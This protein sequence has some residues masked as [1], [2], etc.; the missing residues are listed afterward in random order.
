M[1]GGQSQKQKARKYAPIW[2]NRYI[3]GYWPNRNPLRDAALPV[4]QE[5]FYGALNDALIAGQDCE[6]NLRSELVRRAGTSV[7]NSNTFG[8]QQRFFSFPV[9]GV[10]GTPYRRILASSATQID[11]ITNGGDT[12]LYLKPAGAAKTVFQNIGDTTFFAD[13]VLPQQLLSFANSWTANTTFPYGTEIVDTNGNIQKSLGSAV[14]ITDVNV[15][16]VSGVS[17]LTITFSGT[18]EIAIGD[19]ASFLGLT[20]ATFLNNTSVVVTATT[21]STFSAPI[22]ASA[23]AT[24]A[25]T[26]V[27]YT[28]ALPL[29]SA[30]LQTIGISSDVLTIFFSGVGPSTLVSG[31][32]VTF[33]GITNPTFLFLNGTTMTISTVQYLHGTRYSGS[34]TA[35]NITPTATGSGYIT[36]PGP[37]AETGATQPTWSST[38][39]GVTFDGTTAWVFSGPAVRN[40][41]IVAP[42]TAPIVANTPASTG[43]GT[44]V[45]STYYFPYQIIY[46]PVTLSIQQLITAG[47][48]AGSVPSFSATLG[49]NTTDGGAVW[50]SQGLAARQVSTNYTTGSFI[51][52]TWSKTVATYNPGT[53]IGGKPLNGAPSSGTTTYTTI[54][55]DAFYVCTQAG[56]T[57]SGATGTIDWPLSGTIT[58]GSVVWT[59]V[60]LEVKRTASAS[61]SPTVSTSAF[62]AGNIGNSQLVSIYGTLTTNNGLSAPINDGMNF[63]I[64]IVAGKSGTSAP[65]WAT[66]PGGATSDNGITWF[67][68]GSSGSSANTEEWFYA[69]AF[70]STTTPDVSSASPVSVPIVRATGNWISISGQTSPD[71]QVD[72]IRIY[73]T[74]QQPL[75]TTSITGSQLFWIADIPMPSGATWQYVDTSNDPPDPNS[76]MNIFIIADTTGINTPPADNITNFVYYLGR[77][78]GSIGNTVYA[79]AG[80]DVV[81]GGNPFTAFPPA[82][83]MDFPGTVIRMVASSQGLFVYTSDNVQIVT[84]NGIA[85]T[86]GVSGFT[87]FVPSIYI[88]DL[89]LGN[90]DGLTTDGGTTYVYTADNNVCSISSSGLSWISTAIANNLQTPFTLTNGTVVTFSPENV[91][92][93]WYINGDDY[94]ILVSDGTY[95]FFRMMP[96]TSPDSG[97][98]V[99][100]PFSAIS[101]G[102]SAPAYIQTNNSGQHYVLIGPGTSG[103]IVKRDITVATD[104][105]TTFPW[106]ATFGSIVLAHPGELAMIQSIVIDS[107]MIG[108]HPTITVYFDE[109]NSEGVSYKYDDG[110]YD[111]YSAE[112]STTTYADRFFMT[113]N[114]EACAIC[115]HLQF[116]INFPAEN[117]IN[118]VLSSTIIG[119]TEYDN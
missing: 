58:D 103:P 54:T 68:N 41:G 67:N 9:F 85:S 66:T 47:T 89:T 74:L 78:W 90:Y 36:W 118:T 28:T 95:G 113:D 70:L 50:K 52:A 115:R 40:V 56:A 55:Y 27:A 24:T 88:D 105:G 117:A 108:S 107:V 60:G 109:I 116:S 93:S 4:L 91:Y 83:F 97:N 11:D 31:D 77:L 101:G 15:T 110:V 34:Y 81:N 25:D 17:T 43:G 29:Y 94:G 6:I 23:Y 84:G 45:G 12:L 26:G 18:S 46:D 96:S 57:S 69:Y 119:A 16:V 99:W 98:M 1:S 30:S 65:T 22:N 42:T 51:M 38:Y 10:N 102:V 86:P 61:S 32:V 59:F 64:V 73:R 104:N 53:P 111:P 79:S 14:N 49:T 2:V 19:T 62:T 75:G 76:T 63:E 92:L 35:S 5:K 20:T 100:S 39:Q 33:N 8:V 71:L 80:P 48:T 87:T 7:F 21:G 37:T 13:T 82:N 106:Y 72:T 114:P 112:V 3:S 44:W